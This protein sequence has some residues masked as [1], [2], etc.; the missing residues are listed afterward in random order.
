MFDYGKPEVVHF[1]LSNVRFWLDEY[2]F[3]GFRFDGVTSM[4]YLD[5]GLERS[6][7]SY[8][9]YVSDNI[10]LDALGYLRLANKLTHAVN[11]QAI[12]IAEDTSAFPGLAAPINEGGVGFDYRLSMGV[13]DLWIKTLKEQRDDDWNLSFLFHELTAHRAE[14]K[15]IS[16]AESHD[17]ALVGDKT[18]IFRLIDKEMYYHMSIG[19]D[20]LIVD[21]GIAL[22]K[23]IRLLT[24]TT[25]NGGYLTFMGNE[26]GHPEWIDFPREGNNWSYHYAR[27]QWSLADNPKLKYQFLQ[28]FDV[29]LV[30]LLREEGH[31]E[32]DYITVDQDRKLLSY[33]R[34]DYLFV[35]NLSPTTSYIN[36]EIPAP[37]GSYSLILSS[38]D[39]RFGGQQRVDASLPYVSTNERLKVYIPSRV[40]LVFKLA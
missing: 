20:N 9:D 22:H 34:G 17:Q 13:P 25:N 38:D 36:H 39:T 6:F 21:R 5:H 12:S 11:P 28:N 24:A 4:L 8:D 33:R 35:V 27:R 32:A 2:H 19:D 14:E 23:L 15:T 7:G 30:K 26:F 1:L 3:D 37:N 29:A 31:E 16:Y 18:L 10:D 40:G